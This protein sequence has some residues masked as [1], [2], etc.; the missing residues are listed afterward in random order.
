MSVRKKEMNTRLQGRSDGKG[1]TLETD[2]NL[3]DV[4]NPGPRHNAGLN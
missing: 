3:E 4:R 1:A 2:T